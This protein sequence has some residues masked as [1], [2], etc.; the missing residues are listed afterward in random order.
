MGLLPLEDQGKKKRR[1]GL[2]EANTNSSSNWS[3]DTSYEEGH[4][5]VKIP[6]SGGTANRDWFGTPQSEQQ[7]IGWGKCRG[8][9]GRKKS[10]LSRR[11]KKGAKEGYRLRSL[12]VQSLDQRSRTVSVKKWNL[13]GGER[14]RGSKEEGHRGRGGRVKNGD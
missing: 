10:T 4:L 5:K 13:S 8:G 3:K 12:K 11:A 6:R 1:L 14:N 2:E 9:G 7:A